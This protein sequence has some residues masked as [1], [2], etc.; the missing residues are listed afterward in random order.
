MNESLVHGHDFNRMTALTLILAV[1]LQQQHALAAL[2]LPRI[3]SFFMD[4]SRFLPLSSF[5]LNC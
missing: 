3:F 4:I 1:L 2:L 5:P